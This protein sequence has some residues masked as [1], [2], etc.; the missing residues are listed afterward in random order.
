MIK[1]SLEP[2]F[3]EVGPASN[4]LSAGPGVAVWRLNRG[5][6]A[7]FKWQH[8]YFLEKLGF[9]RNGV[10]NEQNHGLASILGWQKARYLA[11]GATVGEEMKKLLYGKVIIRH[12]S[13]ATNF[14]NEVWWREFTLGLPRDQLSLLFSLLYTGTRHRGFR[15]KVLTAIQRTTRRI[16]PFMDA[17][18]TKFFRREG[19]GGENVTENMERRRGRA[20]APTRVHSGI[21][22]PP[23]HN[24]QPTRKAQ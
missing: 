14:F 2:L 19:H 20:P 4:S 12:H 23:F 11:L 17:N 9:R 1:A 3:T 15:F 7:E 22:T 5:I 24:A 6:E 10:F 16:A 21:S 8:D 13:P 18:F